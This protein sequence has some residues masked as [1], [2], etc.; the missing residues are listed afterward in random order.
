MSDAARWTSRT[1]EK[2]LYLTN[3]LKFLTTGYVSMIVPS[4]IGS[5]YQV[6]GFL[7]EFL[8]PG[9]LYSTRF[10]CAFLV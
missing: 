3:D 5:H 1:R 8:G 9:F 4:A 2:L 6:T 7:F 10:P